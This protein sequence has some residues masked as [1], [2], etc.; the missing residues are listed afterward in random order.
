MYA[1][2]SLYGRTGYGIMKRDD[3]ESSGEKFKATHAPLHEAGAARTKALG[4]KIQPLTL[5]LSRLQLI[6]HQVGGAVAN[7]TLT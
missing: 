4:Y 6:A 7:C 5:L 3:Q 2:R 1:I